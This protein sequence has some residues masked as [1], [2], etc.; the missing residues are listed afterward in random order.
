MRQQWKAEVSTWQELGRE[1]HTGVDMRRRI[2]QGC[3]R[4]QPLHS[5]RPVYNQEVQSKS[6]TPFK[7]DSAQESGVFFFGSRGWLALNQTV[8]GHERLSEAFEMTVRRCKLH[9]QTRKTSSRIGSSWPSKYNPALENMARQF[10]RRVAQ[11]KATIF[12]GSMSDQ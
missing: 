5:V 4:E 9:S 8:N 10:Q 6:K 3:C 1:F 11:G 7:Q 2:A 12:G